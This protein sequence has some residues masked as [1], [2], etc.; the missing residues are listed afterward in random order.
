M[1]VKQEQRGASMVEY[2]IG[3]AFLVGSLTAPVF[4]GNSVVTL[5]ANAVKAEHSA[6]MHATSM[7]L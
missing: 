3:L 6:Y 7:P 4:G 2:A 5:L 1:I